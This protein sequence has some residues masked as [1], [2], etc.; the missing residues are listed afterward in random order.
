MIIAIHAGHNPDGKVACGAVG[1]QK[2]STL[3]REVC[4]YLSDYLLRYEGIDAV[5]D[6]TCNNGKNASDVLNRVVQRTNSIDTDLSISI[7]LNASATPSAN[8][9]EVW[10]YTNNNAMPYLG[11]EI[12]KELEKYGYRNRGVKTSSSLVV[13]RKIKCDSILVECAFVTNRGDMNKFN[14]RQVAKR[15][16]KGIAKYYDLKEAKK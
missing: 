1:F 5:A 8:G 12:C 9:S 4:A 13:L 3:A 2:E 7:H 16:A 14:S 11:N 10:C 6:V 15:I